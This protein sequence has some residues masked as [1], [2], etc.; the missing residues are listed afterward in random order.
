MPLS[1]ERRGK[2]G[3]PYTRT[4]FEPGKCVILQGP[5]HIAPEVHIQALSESQVEVIQLFPGNEVR[6]HTLTEKD[7]NKSRDTRRLLPGI[8]VSWSPTP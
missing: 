7:I 2:P 3:E 1:I 5:T 8:R 4:V 6:R